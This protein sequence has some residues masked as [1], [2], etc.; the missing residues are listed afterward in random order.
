M[1]YIKSFKAWIGFLVLL[2]TFVGFV[3]VPWF[4]TNKLPS[5]L[6]EKVGINVSIKKAD[7]NPYSF[8][9]TLNGVTV[10]DL[11]K[12]AAFEFKKLY[13]NYTLLGLIDKTFLFSDISLDSPLLYATINENGG[14][15]LNNI[16]PK[17]EKKEEKTQSKKT[18]LPKIMLRILDIKNGKIKIQ[19]K[20]KNREFSL[21]L[22]PYNFMAHDIS[23][24]HGEINAYTFQTMIDGGGKIIW[25]G[26]M[27]IEPLKLYGKLVLQDLSLPKI[28][29][30][31]ASNLGA[32]LTKGTLSFTIPYQADISEKIKFS[33]NGARFYLK[34]IL[35]KDK[36]TSQTLINAK[37]INIGNF[38]LEWPKQ[39][40]VIDKLKISGTKIYPKLEKGSKLN[41]ARLFPASPKKQK[42]KKT[43]NRQK[44]WSYL[45]NN[46]VIEN[47]SVY[48]DN[49]DMKKQSK[50]ALRDIALHVEGISSRVKEPI[51]YKLHS[52]L[53]KNSKI[54]IKGT[55]IQ[56]PL[57]IN[58]SI[59]LSNIL[60][61]D[62]IN[63]LNPYINFNL[64]NLSINTKAHIKASFEKKMK[65]ALS[66]DSS[67]NNL[68][69][70]TKDNQKLISWKKVSLEG[71][72]FKNSPLALKIKT[73]KLIKPYIR[74]H[75]AK[76]RSTNFANLV[77]KSAEKSKKHS[78][79][80]TKKQS[81]HLNLVI[82]DIKI[83]D[84]RTDFSDMSVP[85]PFHTSIH[86]LNGY[87]TTLN[88][89]TTTPSKIKIEGKI[90]K[91]GYANIK[92]VLLPFKIKRKADIDVLLKNLDLTTLTPYS[93]K[94]LGYKIKTGKV[95]MDLN[96]KI[97]KASLIG[98]NKINI[99]TLELGEKVKSKDAVN[100]P[101]GLALAL[102]KDSN[103]Q[104]DIDLP[105][106]GDM[107]NPDFSYG[108]IV[109]K[110][111]GNM[112]TG[113]VTAPFKFLGSL[114]GIKGDDL[115]AIDFEQGS[116]KIISSEFEKLDN[117]NKI[118][119]KRPNIKLEIT[120]AYNKT[121][122]KSVLQKQDFA[123]VVEKELKKL[124]KR[125]GVD[126]YGVV[127]KRLYTKEFSAKNYNE[128]RKSFVIKDKKGEKKEKNLIDLTAF[129]A[130]MQND[131]ASKIK[132]PK[133]RLLDLANKRAETI[134]ETLISK[135]KISKDRVK[136]IAPK[137]VQ[138]KRDRW[139]ACELKISI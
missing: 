65:I 59:S 69:I 120:G 132:I 71:I 36:K 112:I 95:S 93:G 6:K 126:A 51:E 27:S 138:T 60:P 42:S 43:T 113:I 31:T 21:D 108:S 15:N 24:I 37:N 125:K 94:F 64:V 116:Y 122:D 109:W 29:R 111:I 104:I 39:N 23:T 115:K 63:Y 76:D 133:K 101:I 89:D 25:K 52:T 4:I 100:L 81:R 102:L 18:S 9:L 46:F 114:L 20:R 49:L 128:L 134:K 54:S 28:Y 98:K 130:K 117:L 107:N 103:D 80:S 135:Y 90:D 72:K 35:L 61:K 5:L 67:L 22:G 127:L 17:S 83:V 40:I 118:M 137:E 34:N 55:V 99:D 110:A 68:L 75:I 97:S 33:I 1:K 124:K 26:G 139:I 136:V 85:F 8:E 131:L 38:N 58:S 10:Y 62:F 77:K 47:T 41:F 19:D 82:G 50:T 13:I 45:L 66:A 2:Y 70:K 105:V 119:G 87:I 44:P 106:K 129:N 92:G 121:A 32:S 56:K 86:D 7:F 123:K 84:A 78:R 11:K 74:A 73:I 57:S 96:Y 14:I 16:M 91:Y 88:F 30:Y 53:N 12:Q 3:A 79:K 48:F